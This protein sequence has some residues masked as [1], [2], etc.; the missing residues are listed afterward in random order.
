MK[1][2]M[3]FTVVLLFAVTLA[4]CET[5]DA[6]PSTS[7]P[8]QATATV[9]QAAEETTTAKTTAEPAPFPLSEPGPYRVGVRTYFGFQ[10]A[11]RDGREVGIRVWYP[12]KP[13]GGATGQKVLSH[14]NADRSGAPW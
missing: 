13:L 5:P 3:S 2:S 12:A 8:P 6:A 11:S 4:S 14:A 7:T 10:D 1:R 9:E